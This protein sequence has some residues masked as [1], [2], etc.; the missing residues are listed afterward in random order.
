MTKYQKLTPL[1][2]LGLAVLIIVLLSAGLAKLRFQPGK[3]F[4]ILAYLLQQLRGFRTAA[5]PGP[6]EEG[7]PTNLWVPIFWFMLLFSIAFAIISP[8]YR[9]F[10]LRLLITAVCLSVLLGLLMDRPWLGNESSNSGAGGAAEQTEVDFPD[11]PNLITNPP[12]W[13]L[14][15]ADVILGL[16]FVGIIWV[17]WRLLRPKPDT[18]TLLVREAELALTGLTTGGDLKNVV[19]RCYVRMSQVLRQSRNIERNQAMTPREFEIHLAEIG[20]RDEHIRRL[21]RLFEGVR[22]GARP[23]SGSAERE[24]IDCL[25]AIVQTYG[26]P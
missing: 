21:T 26:K 5:A 22:Y 19:M 9:R 1:L 14:V 7:A 17:L 11:P 25:Q 23:S 4:N 3:E 15:V 16:L 2:Q 20:L 10:L 8:Q 24:A 6:I 12:T 13:L 18:Q